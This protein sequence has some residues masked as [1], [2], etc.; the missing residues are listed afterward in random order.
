MAL[1]Y[2][3]VGELLQ[4]ALETGGRHTHR[5]GELGPIPGLLRLGE[6]C[7]KDSLAGFGQQSIE[8]SD[9]THNT[10][11]LTLLA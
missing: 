10:K 9:V 1:E 3:G 7:R 5:A 4:F 11:L 8:R 6:R 2:A